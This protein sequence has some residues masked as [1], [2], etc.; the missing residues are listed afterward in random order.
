MI[1]KYIYIRDEDS[2]GKII[3]SK[4]FIHFNKLLAKKK[5]KYIIIVRGI[6]SSF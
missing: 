3:F 4:Y 6:I 2:K 5:K 1:I